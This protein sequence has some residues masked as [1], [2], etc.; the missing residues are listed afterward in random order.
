[1]FTREPLNGLMFVRLCVWVCL[2]QIYCYLSGRQ[3]DCFAV[4]GG[5]N[6]SLK[7][8]KDYILACFESIL[9]QQT[10]TPDTSSACRIELMG[11]YKVKYSLQGNGGYNIA[12]FARNLAYSRTVL[13]LHSCLPILIIK[14]VYVAVLWHAVPDRSR[15]YV[16][17]MEWTLMYMGVLFGG[18][19]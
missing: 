19:L 6:P 8:V 16:H 11:T 14:Q 3:A 18:I 7:T 9:Q 2:I 4:S 1:M 17:D 10:N 13:S 15:S 5:L 12:V